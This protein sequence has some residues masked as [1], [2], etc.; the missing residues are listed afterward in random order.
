V[1]VENE[2]NVPWGVTVRPEPAAGLRFE[3]AQAALTV[4]PG[5]QEQVP[6]V[7]RSARRW[8]G[9]PQSRTF[10]VH[11]DP[12]SQP[13]PEA[14]TLAG[15]RQ[16]L[17]FLPL[18]LLPLLLVLIGLGFAAIALFGGDAV[19]VPAV[20]DQPREQAVSQL[21]DARFQAETPNQR[22]RGLQIRADGGVGYL[23]Y[24]TD[25]AWAVYAAAGVEPGRVR[26]VSARIASN[27]SG[28]RLELMLGGAEGAVVAECSI[29]GTG[30][31]LA[32][33]TITCDVIGDI[34]TRP[35]QIYL[36]F[37]GKADA[38]NPYLSNVDWFELS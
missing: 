18:W 6:V 36:Q 1:L 22:S 29:P 7:A 24:I 3:K 26:T 16:Q 10:E 21:K 38:V 5:A 19:A 34:A 15:T 32:W 27:T 2:G 28:G 8:F 33:Q 23:S 25:G 9:S 31:W 13:A 20:G 30:G 37:S 17:P 35:T 4:V 14:A 12:T 11:V